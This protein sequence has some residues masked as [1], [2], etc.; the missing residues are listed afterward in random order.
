[1]NL[2]RIVED[3]DTRGGRAFALFIQAMILVSLVTFSL[4]TLPDL[5]PETRYTLYVLEV[6]TVSVFTIEYA[7]RVLVADDRL[8]FVTSFYGLIDLVA[9]LPF[10]VTTGLDL[11]TA[12]VLRL[13]RVFRIFKFARYTAALDRIKNAFVTI[14]EELVIYIIATLL[15]VFLSSVGIY[16]FESDTQPELFGSVFHCFWWAIVTLTTVGYGDVY[17]LTI[18]GRVFTSVVML[19]GIG[20]IAVPTGLFATALSNTRKTDSAA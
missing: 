11:R 9:I 12:R 2:K 6:I 20:I 17:P 16:Y 4:E 18:G 19:L 3:T 13:F 14:R 7:L 10:Y 5:E 15:M 1:M 8:R